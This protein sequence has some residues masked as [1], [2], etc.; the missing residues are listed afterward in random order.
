MSRRVELEKTLRAGKRVSKR[1]SAGGLFAHY[2]QQGTGCLRSDQIVCHERKPPAPEVQ[3]RA[4]K[5]T[6]GRT[7]GSLSRYSVSFRLKFGRGWRTL[8]R[9]LG[10]LSRYSVSFHPKFSQRG[11]TLGRGQLSE[12]HGTLSH[13]RNRRSH[14]GPSSARAAQ[15]YAA[16]VRRHRK[17]E[18]PGRLHRV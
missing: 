12:S 2:T 3:T 8:G 5:R 1:T 14:S 16:P 7:L 9:T 17:Q 10:S 11:R 13:W 15:R 6:L 4:E 18:P